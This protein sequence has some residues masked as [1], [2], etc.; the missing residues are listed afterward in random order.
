VAEAGHRQRQRSSN[1]EGDHFQNRGGQRSGPNSISRQ[2]QIKKL[3]EAKDTLLK[4]VGKGLQR[5]VD[6]SCSVPIFR[7]TY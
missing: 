6:I 1:P 3:Y 7:F 4:V 5:K 2:A